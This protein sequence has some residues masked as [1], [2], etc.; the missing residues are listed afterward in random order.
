ML[1]ILRDCL[2]FCFRF[3]GKERKPNGG[4][5]LVISSNFIRVVFHT[6]K[7]THGLGFRISY[8]AIA[9]NAAN[10]N[11]LKGMCQI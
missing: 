1:K 6:D 11:N 9:T 8:E 4:D 7:S 3:C 5:S 10:I 2:L